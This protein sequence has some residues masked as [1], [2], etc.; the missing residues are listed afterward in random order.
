MMVWFAYKEEDYVLKNISFEAKK[1]EKIAFVGAT[2]AGKSSI[3]NFINRFYEINQGRILV[4]G[5]DVK[6]YGYKP[7]VRVS[8]LYSKIFSC[9]L[10]LFER[11]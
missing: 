11:I 8:D 3:I 5:I 2:G 9:F 4:D 10:G 6:E 7:C 1:G